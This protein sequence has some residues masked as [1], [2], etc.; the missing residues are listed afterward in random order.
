[1]L[2]YRFIK[3][4]LDAVK[5][6]IVNR[7]MNA[8]A[9][10]V[11]KLFDKKRVREVIEFVKQNGGI[12]YTKDMMQKYAADAL[13]ILKEMPENEYRNSLELLVNYVMTREK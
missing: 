1:M 5:Q 7:N 10:L 13:E 2:D 9:D 11:V 12:E 4:Y 6:N 3:E 8:D